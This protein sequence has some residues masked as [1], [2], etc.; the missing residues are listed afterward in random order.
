MRS[1]TTTTEVDGVPPRAREHPSVAERRDRGR[2]ARQRVPRRSLAAWEPAADR[3]DPVAILQAQ[4]ETRVSEL[5]PL[6][7]GRMLVSPF[8]FYR[9]SAAIMAADLGPIPTSGIT[10]QVCG[11]AHLSNFGLF[12]SPER[13]LVFDINDFDETLPGPWEWDV[14]RLATSLEIAGRHNGFSEAQRHRV[15][16][17]AVASYRT[18]MAA[19]AA[20]PNLEVWYTRSNVQAGLPRLRAMLDKKGVAQA[21]KVI[22]KAMSKDSAQASAR[23][24]QVV[25]GERL[26]KAVSQALSSSGIDPATLEL[27]LTE[28]ILMQNIAEKAALLNRLGELGVGLSI[29]DF[30]TGYSSLSYLKT[31]P[32]DSIK[33][34]SSFVRDIHSDPN[35]EAIIKAI[36]A[37]A[38]SLKL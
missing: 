27:E 34:D 30:G 38:H 14:R 19:L 9:G 33:I 18:V 17:R 13:T 31:L 11:D 21:E 12:A 28:S 7:Y 15:A 10:T 32:V 26:Y 4:G 3:A 35:D 8:T 22:R 29:D 24:T 36:L 1:A 2:A 6:R 25:D 37:M 20:K 5:V 23:L 16:K